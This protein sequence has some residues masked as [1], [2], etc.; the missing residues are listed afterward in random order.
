MANVAPPVIGRGPDERIEVD[1]LVNKRWRVLRGLT[2]SAWRM[3]V[4]D[5]SSRVRESKSIHPLTSA[6]SLRHQHHLECRDLVWVV[7]DAE[8]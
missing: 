6:R 8:N 4:R 5:V 7:K 1:F 3:E 2:L